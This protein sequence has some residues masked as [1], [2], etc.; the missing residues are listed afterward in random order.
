MIF[1]QRTLTLTFQIL[2]LQDIGNI[3]STLFVF[4]DDM[5]DELTDLP[6]YH[7]IETQTEFIIEKP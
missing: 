4:T 3:M 1:N 5:I 6:P 2:H 7:D